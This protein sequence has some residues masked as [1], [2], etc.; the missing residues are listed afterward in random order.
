LKTAAAADGISFFWALLI[1]TRLEE[2][3]LGGQ[4]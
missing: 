1:E 2:K 4:R 3:Q